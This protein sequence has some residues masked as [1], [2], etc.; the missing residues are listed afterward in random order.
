MPSWMLSGLVRLG[1]LVARGRSIFTECVSSGAVM[2]KMTSRTSI[3]SISGIML[4]SAMGASAPLRWNPPKATS[5]R[6][7]RGRGLER[8]HGA[9]LAHM[10][11]RGEHGEKVV[12]ETVQPRERHAVGAHEGVVG[13]HCR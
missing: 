1:V 4:I 6:S 10:R 2:M 12:R 3:T 7:G 9:A 13:Q 11:T 8:N 5:G